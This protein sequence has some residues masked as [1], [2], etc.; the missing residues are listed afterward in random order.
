MDLKPFIKEEGIR[1]SRAK[2]F[3]DPDISEI[4]VRNSRGQVVMWLDRKW[5]VPLSTVT[6]VKVGLSL[7]KNVTDSLPGEL[8]LMYINGRKVQLLI[9]QARQLS[10]GL[11]RQASK[12]DDWQISRRA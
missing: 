11:I 4:R 1:L 2:E 9:E 12:A 5:P 7:A 10:G 8:V 6:A 3:F